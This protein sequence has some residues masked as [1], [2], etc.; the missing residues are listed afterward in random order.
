M[1]SGP[2]LFLDHYVDCG[3][4]K[5][6]DLFLNFHLIYQLDLHGQLRIGREAGAEGLTEFLEVKS[7][8]GW[9]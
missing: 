9:N 6:G 5:D 2:D 1:D 7:V 4:E 8:G 3:H